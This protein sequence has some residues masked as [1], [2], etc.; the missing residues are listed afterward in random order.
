MFF[1]GSS[2]P[3]Q[4]CNGKAEDCFCPVYRSTSWSLGLLIIKDKILFRALLQAQNGSIMTF[5]SI[6]DSRRHLLGPDKRSIFAL[7][8]AEQPLLTWDKQLQAEQGEPAES[9][10]VLHEQFKLKGF[11]KE[12][13]VLPGLY[14]CFHP[15]CCRRT[16]VST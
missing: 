11:C 8:K 13:Q 9:R 10:C 2:P 15:G 16:R 14:H 7:R 1:S 5:P 6:F 4:R 12:I 3:V